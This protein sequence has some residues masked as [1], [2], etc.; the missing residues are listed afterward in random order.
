MRGLAAVLQFKALH[1]CYP[2]TLAGAGVTDKDPLDGKPLKL[3]ITGK[4]CRVY[5]VGPDREDDDG[6]RQGESATTAN[7]DKGWDIVASY[8]A[9]VPRGR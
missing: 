3:R 8:P 6:V 5:S 7:R 2:K 4:E 9:Y 1:G